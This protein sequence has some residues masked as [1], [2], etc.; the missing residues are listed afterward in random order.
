MSKKVFI[1]GGTGFVGSYIIK[2]LIEKGYAVRAMRRSAK[3]PFYIPK[4]IFD[5]VEWVDGDILDVMAIEEAMEGVDTIIHSAA[6]VS[7]I[8][9]DRKQMYKI[10]V[11]GTANM[12]NMAIEKNINRF[13]YI[14][15][16]AA[17]G[18]TAHGG[19]VNEDKKWEE[20]KMNTHY[21]KSK[22]RAELE[23]WRAAGEGLNTLIL[24]PSTVLGYGDWNTGSSA[25]FK[26]VYKEFKW[27]SPGI[28]GFVDVEDL[29]NATVLLMESGLSNERY[30]V[31]GDNWPFRKLMDVISGCFGKKKP[32]RQTTPF[33]MSIAWRM[34]KFKS[35]FTKERPL[36]T[37]ES[38][39]IAH[40]KTY[41]E[42]DKIL[43]ALPGFSFTPLEES[44]QN[45]CEKYLARL[46]KLQP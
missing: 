35:F 34:E 39:R 3:L 16:V 22:Y 31:N 7:F 30:I 26:N 36:L 5:R 1:T 28:N 46:N 19:H 44:I 4:E 2:A 45:S 24:N 8:K 29:A 25:I 37:R 9:K 41:F 21:A 42:N 20:S 6:I 40:S 27:Y 17:L 38:A 14:S 11:E 18:R 23:V 12:V 15:S 33:L 10:N 13:V 43:K 32:L